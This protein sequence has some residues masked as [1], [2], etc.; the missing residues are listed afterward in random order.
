MVRIEEIRNQAAPAKN[1]VPVSGR[2]GNSCMFVFVFR[3]NKHISDQN[4]RVNSCMRNTFYSTPI[5]QDCS[6][7]AIADCG[8]DDNCFVS[9]AQ[10]GFRLLDACCTSSE[11]F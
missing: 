7:F 6:R 5:F 9:P 8:D 11:D 1:V 3:G 4:S 10:A 2:E